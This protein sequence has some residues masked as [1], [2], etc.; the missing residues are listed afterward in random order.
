[1]PDPSDLA[2][3]VTALLL[4]SPFCFR[5]LAEKS[6]ATRSQIAQALRGIEGTLMIR[7]ST[8]RCRGCGEHVEA[9]SLAR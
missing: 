3:T 9:V 8:Q 2:A 7:F 5:C 1:M 6:G 4:E